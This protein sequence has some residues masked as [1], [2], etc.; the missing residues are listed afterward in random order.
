[1]FN[2]FTFPNNLGKTG[3]SAVAG[4]QFMHNGIR[5]HCNK[6]LFVIGTYRY[7]YCV[8]SSTCRQPTVKLILGMNTILEGVLL[9]FWSRPLRS[10]ESTQGMELSQRLMSNRIVLGSLVGP[11]SRS[12]RDLSWDQ[13]GGASTQSSIPRRPIP[14]HSKRLL[15]GSMVKIGK[16]RV[17]S[18]LNCSVRNVQTI[19]SLKREAVG[20]SSRLVYHITS[21]HQMC[22]KVDR[23]VYRIYFIS[24]SRVLDSHN[25]DENRAYLRTSLRQDPPS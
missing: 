10:P 21:G 16:G 1:M 17:F 12:S 13:K 9:M 15:L 4:G 22:P 24:P 3:S 23:A 25:P 14:Q 18:N 2:F 6:D 5:K 11:S 20:L 19:P 8:S 7:L